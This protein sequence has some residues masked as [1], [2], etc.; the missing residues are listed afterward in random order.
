V[1]TGVGNYS[2]RNMGPAAGSHTGVCTITMTDD[3]QFVV[4][5]SVAEAVNKADFHAIAAILPIDGACTPTYVSFD[6][7]GSV[8]PVVLDI[9]RIQAIA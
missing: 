8:T 4:A 6:V 3:A 5:H 1:I 9:R 2:S 7:P